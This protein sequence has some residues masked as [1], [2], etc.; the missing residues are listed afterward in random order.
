M[1]PLSDL[2]LIQAEYPGHTH[3]NP[4]QLAAGRR[5]QEAT[6]RAIIELIDRSPAV[7][8][9]GKGGVKELLESLIEEGEGDE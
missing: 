1:L 5:L 4:A 2:E 3:V 7:L 9:A 8:W 6:I